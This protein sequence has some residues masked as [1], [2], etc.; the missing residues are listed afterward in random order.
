VF[1]YTNTVQIKNVISYNANIF[2][3]FLIIIIYNSNN[4][5]DMDG[6]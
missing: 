1:Y 3:L 6:L 5:A 2:I 4:Q